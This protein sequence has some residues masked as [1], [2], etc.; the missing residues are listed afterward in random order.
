M[1]NSAFNNEN[2]S[3]IH[4]TMNDNFDRIVEIEKKIVEAREEAEKA[5]KTAYDNTSKVGKI[6]GH[7]KGILENREA[8]KNTANAVFSISQAQELMFEH[9]KELANIADSISNL[10]ASSI[11]AN[12]KVLDE[13]RTYLSGAKSANLSDFSRK[14][15]LELTKKLA[16]YKSQME[17]QEENAQAV[18]EI[19][20]QIA[21]I[22]RWMNTIDDQ[23]SDIDERFSDLDH[24]MDD[25]Y[26]RI[27]EIDERVTNN[28]EHLKRH[29]IEIEN[30]Q[31]KINKRHKSLEL[32]DA[33]ID[34]V[35]QV[36]VKKTGSK[37]FG[38]FLLVVSGYLLFCAVLGL[39]ALAI[40]GTFA[41]MEI[42]EA[43]GTV[44]FLIIWGIISFIVFWKGRKRIKRK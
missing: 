41:T 40:S 15:L 17:A 25:I 3:Q 35:Q 11:A 33:V 23:L 13:L 7:Q 31:E 38:Y 24:E 39:F 32:A 30:L 10:G 16:L 29:D 21:K 12:T 19:E 4:E 44:V 8:N 14:K 5:K 34:K 26:N 22:N 42:S 27:D 18:K 1:S 37:A 36:D 28:A 6:F 20:E 43:I 9:I 2:F